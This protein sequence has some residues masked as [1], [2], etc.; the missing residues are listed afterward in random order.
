M[1]E[2][3]ARQLLNPSR[4]REF[5]E[6]YVLLAIE[7]AGR[8]ELIEK[9]SRKF[10]SSGKT[11][12]EFAAREILGLVEVIAAKGKGGSAL[13]LLLHARSQEKE[14]IAYKTKVEELDELLRIASD[15]SKAGRES[16]SELLEARGA[17]QAAIERAERAESEIEILR[18]RPHVDATKMDAQQET[19][20]SLRGSLAKS[21]LVIKELRDEL[22]AKEQSLQASI[23]SAK[24]APHLGNGRGKLTAA[25]AKRA[26]GAG[27]IDV[28]QA[29]EMME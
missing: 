24:V 25:Q 15:E 18:R 17:C 5:A 2:S 27:L 6:E 3:E 26:I 13:A 4:W 28:A 16:S 20:R 1:N 21:E 9:L 8:Q 22:H 10:K 7:G 19:I 12:Q 14:L 23:L 29:L 11:G